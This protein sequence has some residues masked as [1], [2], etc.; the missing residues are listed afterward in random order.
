MIADVLIQYKWV[1]TAAL[2]L[3][4]AVGP[5]VGMALVRHPRLAWV[6]TGLTLLPVAALTLVPV[7]RQLFEVCSVQWSLPTVG[8]VE[9]MANVVLFVLPVLFAGVASRKPL[10][11]LL[12]A[13][14]LSVT[15]EVFQ[16]LVPAIGRSCDTNDWLNNTI[17]AAIGAVLAIVAVRLAKRRTA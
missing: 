13:S 4:V 3:F 2:V 5:F 6:L 1:A 8:R 10:R 9:L 12:A 16:A 17:G 14:V 7:R 11:M 15:I